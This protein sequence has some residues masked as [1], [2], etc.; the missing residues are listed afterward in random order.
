VALV[1]LYWLH[2][3]GEGSKDEREPSPTF[4]TLQEKQRMQI[5]R[6]SAF[7]GR[8]H[9]REIDVT[10]EQL[11]AWEGGAMAQDAMPHLSADDRE[12]IMTG[13]TPEEWARAFGEDE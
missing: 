1:G 3:S 5:T 9:T 10:M 6:V 13:I 4:E 2:E 7:S 12:F 11:R 8:C